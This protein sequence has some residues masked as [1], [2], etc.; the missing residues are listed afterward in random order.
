MPRLRIFSGAFLLPFI[1][2]AERPR[3]PAEELRWEII[4]LERVDRRRSFA[5]EVQ[6]CLPDGRPVEGMKYSWEIEWV[7]ARSDDSKC[8]VFEPQQ[9]RAR[10]EAGIAVLRI[11]VKTEDGKLL[12]VAKKEFEVR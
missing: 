11:S 5:F 7:G 4:L 10:G 2:C 1:G 3:I 12:Q 9:V 8:R 6:S